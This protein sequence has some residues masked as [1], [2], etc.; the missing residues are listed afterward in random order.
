MMLLRLIILLISTSLIFFGWDNLFAATTFT[1]APTILMTWA[2]A[3]ARFDVAEVLVSIFWS[4]GTELQ[5]KFESNTGNF[6]WVFYLSGSIGW[7][8]FNSGSDYQ[9]TLNCGTQDLT[10]LTTACHLTGTWWSEIVGDVDFSHVDYIPSLGELSGS[11]VTFAGDISL[12]G[13]YLPLRKSEFNED[14]SSLVASPNISLSV[15]WATKYGNNSWWITYSPKLATESVVKSWDLN[16]VFS[17][18]FTF[19]GGYTITITDPSG[20]TTSHDAVV[21]PNIL[22][23]TFDTSPNFIHTFCSAAKHPNKCPDGSDLSATTIVNSGSNIVA[24]GVSYYDVTIKPRDTYGN[25]VNTGGISISYTGTVSSVQIPSDASSAYDTYANFH[26]ALIFSWET[27]TPDLNGK[28]ETSLI[29]L[30]WQDIFYNIASVAP[31]DGTDNILKLNQVQYTRL[32]GSSSITDP[33]GI[34]FVPPFVTTITPPTSIRV[35]EENVFGEN[36]TRNTLEVFVPKVFSLFMIGSGSNAGFRDFAANTPIDCQA[37]PQDPTSYSGSCDWMWL[38]GN[39]FPS[40]LSI[41]T[42]SSFSLTGTYSPF[43]A[44]PTQESV[45]YATYIHYKDT[46]L[47]NLSNNYIVSPDIVYPSGEWTLWTSEFQAS[48]V[49]SLGQNN[50]QGEY[51]T[52]GTSKVTRAKLIDSIRKNVAVLSRNRINGYWWTS[53][54]IQNED[55]TITWGTFDDKRTIVVIGRNVTISENIGHKDHPLAIIALADN[56][57]NGG[58]ILINSTVTDIDASLIAE[59]SVHSSGDHQLYI[60]GSVISENTLGDTAA[61]ICPYYVSVSCTEIEA[62]KYDFENLRAGFDGTDNT[63]KAISAT[64]AN[65]PN[66]PLIIEYDMRVQSDP[67][68]IVAQ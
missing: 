21:L 39:L 18:D 49:K 25:R 60:H 35:G 6:K 45:S 14:I 22:S 48:K 51:G 31:T 29:T 19:A 66:T 9:V 37:Y 10:W 27:F 38:G 44:Y 12:S 33:T 67:P 4:T 28:W 64:A 68:P 16:W 2:T 53:Y 57:G 24:D 54:I 32:S 55:F 3:S 41:Q 23:T 65:Y 1:P 56:A 43:T 8:T 50:A 46:D 17:W 34:T 7:V 11:V 13:I 5:P 58:D 59:H 61:R 42:W 52:I 62:A 30:L 40:V 63:K 36:V 15:S 47:W 26:D 20:S